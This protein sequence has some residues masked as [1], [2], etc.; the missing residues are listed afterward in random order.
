MP[1]VDSH[2]RILP[3]NAVV[4]IFLQKDWF[5]NSL[6][7]FAEVEEK[8]SGEQSR[9]LHMMC[10]LL[11]SSIL[12]T[13]KIAKVK[14]TDKFQYGQKNASGDLRFLVYHDKS[15]KPFQV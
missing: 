11:T 4:N 8:E 7:S 1:L 15:R 6:S 5:D 13:G 10:R 9:T 2:D 12:A 14:V 3:G